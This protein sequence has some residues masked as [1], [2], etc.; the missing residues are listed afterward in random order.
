MNCI[1]IDNSLP[2]EAAE[3][4]QKVFVEE[5]KFENEFDGIDKISFHFVLYKDGV[6]AGTARMFTEDGGKTYQIGRVAVLPEYRKYKFGSEI[7]NAALKKAAEL[8]GE[9]A[10]VSAQCR[11]RHF[12][13][14]LGF[15][16][17]GSVYYDEYCPHVHMEKVL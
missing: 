4:R 13:E 8:G 17:S 16:A 11:V 1:K 9:K 2:K 5:Q 6:A 7:M 12:Y 10:A 14:S 3:I 15:S